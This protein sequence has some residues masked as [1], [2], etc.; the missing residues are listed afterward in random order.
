M[1]NGAKYNKPDFFGDSFR[2]ESSPT[3]TEAPFA[4]IESDI[5]CPAPSLS[6]FI[7]LLS[8]SGVEPCSF[9]SSLMESAAAN[10]VFNSFLFPSLFFPAEWKLKREPTT[11]LSLLLVVSF[12]LASASV[13][14][15][16]ALFSHVLLLSLPTVVSFVGSLRSESV[17]GGILKLK[18]DS[19]PLISA[20][21]SSNV[22]VATS[23]EV[24]TSCSSSAGT[25]AKSLAASSS[26]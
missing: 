25:N 2:E 24:A 3:L 22:L 14:S 18:N 5:S 21:R 10:G 23:W 16:R 17:S 9:V 1:F 8:N 19:H 20:L 12:V 15:V 7:V 13:S 26:K 4:S 11:P 6:P